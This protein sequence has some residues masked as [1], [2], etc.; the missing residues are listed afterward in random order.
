MTTRLFVVV[1]FIFILLG[2]HL[3]AQELSDDKSGAADGLGKYGCDGSGL[4][5]FGDSACWGKNRNEQTREEKR[6][7]T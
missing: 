4:D 2:G 3:N 6:R 5:F 7:K 1:I